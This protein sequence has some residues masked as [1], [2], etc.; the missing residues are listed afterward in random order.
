M[1]RPTRQTFVSQVFNLLK[2]AD[3]FMTGAAIEEQLKIGG[4]RVSASLH[5][6]Y[7]FH[8]I[9]VMSQGNTLYWYATPEED[10]RIR[11]RETIVEE[12][13]RKQRKPGP[14]PRRKLNEIPKRHK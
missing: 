3:D 11:I 4:S 8:A 7:Q 2:S 5:N 13:S 12:C 1:K 14:H 10:R 6:L 9:D